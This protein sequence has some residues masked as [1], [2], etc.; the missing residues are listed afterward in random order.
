M[1]CSE[2]PCDLLDLVGAVLC[3]VRDTGSFGDSRIGKL[4]SLNLETGDVLA[5]SA[6]TRARPGRSLTTYSDHRFDDNADDRC[7]PNYAHNTAFGPLN[8]LFRRLLPGP[9]SV[10]VR[11]SNP[12]SPTTRTP[13]PR[14]GVLALCWTRV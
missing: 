2:L 9:G 10:G 14:S 1:E 12:L 3:W 8:S 6:S 5:A 7:T 13:W 4:Y 11:G